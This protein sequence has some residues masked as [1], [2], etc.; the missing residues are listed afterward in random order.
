MN[1]KVKS[2]L[3]QNKGKPVSPGIIELAKHMARVAVQNNFNLKDAP[4]R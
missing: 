1:K 4:G 3:N 2:K